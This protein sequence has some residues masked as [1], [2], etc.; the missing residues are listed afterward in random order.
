MNISQKN[1]E[2]WADLQ[3]QTRISQI[4]YLDSTCVYERFSSI[5][6]PKATVISINEQNLHANLVGKGISARTFIATQEPHESTFNLFWHTAFECGRIVDLTAEQ[7]VNRFSSGAKVYYPEIINKVATYESWEVALQREEKFQDYAILHYLVT[8]K[9]TGVSKNISRLHYRE[10]K[11]YEVIS[12]LALNGL[13]ESLEAIPSK[14]CI[15]VHCKAG[16]GRTGTLIT[17]CILKE[18]I[19]SGEIQE[20]DLESSLVE[21]I[22]KLRMQRGKY[23]V[24]NVNQFKLLLDYGRHLLK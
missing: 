9:V 14:E 19:V 20:S 3:H 8:E 17:A 15:L 5:R 18:K 21:L 10:W 2:L 13:V 16:V 4:E 22:L 1:L 23:F 24:E 7:S 12:I 11:D 6:C